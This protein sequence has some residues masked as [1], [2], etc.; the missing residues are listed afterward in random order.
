M[1]ISFWEI[2]EDGVVMEDKK[3][4]WRLKQGL[5][6]YKKLRKF[7][8][9]HSIL[10]GLHGG[11]LCKKETN[12]LDVLAGTSEDST[13]SKQEF[14]SELSRKFGYYLIDEYENILFMF[15]TK[16]Y[17]KIHIYFKFLVGR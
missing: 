9:K 7:A 12:D 4:C 16:D 6:E 15:Y 8:L 3:R 14:I 1:D 13:L 17:K 2:V 10:V 11:I 5:K